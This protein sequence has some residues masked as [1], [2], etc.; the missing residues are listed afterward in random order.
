MDSTCVLCRPCFFN[1]IHVKHNYKMH[2]SSGG[3]YCDCGD[4]E[5]WRSGAACSDHQPAKSGDDVGSTTGPEDATSSVEEELQSELNKL[6]DHI[7][8]LPSSLVLRTV[9]LL[10]PLVSSAVVCLNDLLQGSRPIT[11]LPLSHRPGSSDLR[12]TLVSLLDVLEDWRLSFDDSEKK[13]TVQS[14]VDLW[15]SDDC[16]V[17]EVADSPDVWDEWPPPITHVPLVL[18]SMD[19]SEL[20][21]D[22][23]PRTAPKRRT[24]VDVEAR[25]LAQLARARRLH[26]QLFPPRP[27][28]TASDRT[29]ASHAFVVI[30]HNNEFHNY[31]QV[32]KTLRRVMGCSTQQATYHA[33]VVNRDGRSVLQT[34]LSVSQA[35]KTAAALMR[36]SSSLSNRPLHCS[37]EHADVYNMGMFFTL[38]LRWLVHLS[39]QVPS[40][41]PVICHTL[42]GLFHSDNSDPLGPQPV[43]PIVPHGEMMQ[44]HS[45]LAA[46]L[47]RHCL[48]W[49]AVRSETLRVI[50][51]VLLREP[52]FRRVFAIQFTR[53]YAK[54]L[55]QYVYD[56]HTETDNLLALSCQVFTV[57]S[58]ARQL[59][60]HNSV[61]VRVI[62]RLEAAFDTNSDVL[63]DFYVQPSGQSAASDANGENPGTA[64]SNATSSDSSCFQFLIDTLRRANPFE[65]G[66]SQT[67]QSA[68]PSD[69]ASM[70]SDNYELGRVPPEPR[71]LVWHPGSTL[72]RS[73]FHP[74]E[75]LFEVLRCTSYVLGSLTN[76]RPLC[77]NPPQS[78][79]W[80][81][82]AGRGNFIEYIRSFL[83]L[84]G[85]VQ[86]MNGMQRE[87][88]GHVEEE[89]EWA[90]GFYII[91]ELISVLGL[92]AQVASSDYALFKSV[93]SEARQAFEYRIG[94]LD[95]RFRLEPLSSSNDDKAAVGSDRRPSND[96]AFRSLG[97]STEV[98]AYDVATYRFSFMQPLPRFLASL[99]GHGLE[100]G[101]SFED[102]GLGD[103]AFVNLLIE[104]PLQALAF[105]AQY[106]AKMWVRNGYAVPQSVNNMFTSN[107]RVELIDRDLQLLQIAAAILPPDEF[108][109]RFIH[110]M[111]L[112]GYLKSQAPGEPGPGRVQ[113]VEVMLRTLLTLVTERSRPSVGSFS[114]DYIEKAYGTSTSIKG[115]VVDTDLELHHAP[116]ID[117]VIHT[118]CLRPMICSELLSHLPYQPVGSLLR[119]PLGSVT[120]ATSSSH[121]A[122]NDNVR[123]A[124]MSRKANKQAVE[125]ILPQIL[126]QL[127][128]QSHV[129]GRVVFTIKPQVIA[130]RFNRFYSGYRHAEQTAA[131]TYVS[132]SLKI[133]LQSAS[134]PPNDPNFP[135]NLPIPPP[136]PRPLRTFL[137]HMT[138]GILGLVRCETFV[139]L[140]R[141]LLNITLAHGTSTVWWSDTL[142]DLILHL[143]SVALYEDEYEYSKT[144]CFPFLDAVARVPSHWESE[145]ELE[146]LARS[147]HWL[148]PPAPN[149]STD[150]PEQNCLTQCLMKLLQSGRHEEQVELI[151][152]TLN[153]WNKV[154]HLRRQSHTTSAQSTAPG[155]AS[156]TLPLTPA[157]S[158]V[159]AIRQTRAELAKARRARIMAHMS[160]MQQTFMSAYNKPTDENSQSEPMEVDA[161]TETLTADVESLIPTADSLEIQPA[162]GPK[163]LISSLTSV[164][165][166]GMTIT[167]NL[168]LEEVPANASSRMVIAAH[169][170]RTSILS[171]QNS[172]WLEGPGTSE[173]VK[174]LSNL[175]NE[176]FSKD[177]IQ[178]DPSL[179]ISAI[180]DYTGGKSSGALDAFLA[181]VS[182]TAAAARAGTP[183]GGLT[184]LSELSC[185]APPSETASNADQREGTSNAE[186]FPVDMCNLATLEQIVRGKFDSS[187][188]R[189]LDP[190]HPRPLVASRDPI[191]EEGSFISCC[192]HPMHAA[193]KSKYA[194]QLK[195]RVDHMN[196]HRSSTW[197]VFDFRCPLCKSIATL[198][199]P[200]LGPLQSL[201]PCTWLQSRLAVSTGELVSRPTVRF[202]PLVSWLCGLHRWL[203]LY[204][205]QTVSFPTEDTTEYNGRDRR[206]VPDV[207]KR[208][209]FNLFRSLLWDMS[210]EGQ[211]SSGT[212]FSELV[213]LLL[214]RLT[215]SLLIQQDEST[216]RQSLPSGGAS[217]LTGST[218]DAAAT[219][220][221]STRRYFWRARR[222]PRRSST[223]TAEQNAQSAE[224]VSAEST[225]T[226]FTALEHLLPHPPD[227]PVVSTS[228]LTMVQRLADLC[229]PKPTDAL[230]QRSARRTATDILLGTGPI[231]PPTPVDL[232]EDEEPFFT[233]G[234]G[235]DAEFQIGLHAT[236][237][238][239][240]SNTLSNASADST[241]RS[242]HPMRQRSRSGSNNCPPA[243]HEAIDR[244]YLVLKSF[245][246][247]LNA[248]D[249]HLRDADHTPSNSDAQSSIATTSSDAK[250]GNH[251][252]LLARAALD[253]VCTRARDT[254]L[255]AAYEWRALRHTMAYTL[256]SSERALRQNNPREHFFNGGLAERRLH[257]LGNVIQTSLA[258]HSRHALVSRG[259]YPTCQQGEEHQF[260]WP[261]LRDNPT[262]WW[263]W[264]YC[265]PVTVSS[266][267]ET[268]P[269]LGTPP[270]ILH[271]AELSL[272]VAATED[273]R[274]LWHLLVPQLTSNVF[275]PDPLDNV[276]NGEPLPT[277]TESV[278]SGRCISD[279]LVSPSFHNRPVSLLWEV[280]ITF[281][282]LSLL[283][284]RPGLEEDGVVSCQ[285]ERDAAELTAQMT[286][287][288]GPGALGPTLLACDQGRPRQPIG[289][290]H[291]AHL[292][293]LC[294]TAVLVQALLAWM[295]TGDDTSA[296]SELYPL[297]DD[298]QNPDSNLRHLGWY[299]P[300][301]LQ[302]WQRL[303]LLAG[304]PPV[305]GVSSDGTGNGLQSR[306]QSLSLYLRASCL[307]FLRIAAF[308]IYQITGVPVPTWLQQSGER[309]T[310]RPDEY[311]TLLTYLDLPLGPTDLMV[312][313]SS[314]PAESVDNS[315]STES[316]RSMLD[317]QNVSTLSE[318]LWLARLITSWCLAGRAALSRRLYRRLRSHFVS[319]INDGEP[320]LSS[321]NVQPSLDFPLLPNPNLRIPRLIHL[322]REYTS[323]LSLTTDFHCH[324]GG[325]VH[326]D[327][328]VCLVCGHMACLVCYG[329]RLIEPQSEASIST[330][331]A[332]RELVVYDMQ[333][334]SRRCHS[335]YSLTL[336]LH[337]CRV[338]LLSDQAR[339]L[340][341][342]TSPYRDS[343][344]ETDPGLRRG[345]P[346][347]LVDTEYERL[348][349]LWLSHQ[350]ASST[351][352]ELLTPPSLEMGMI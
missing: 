235:E 57:I 60:E 236:T 89:L 190:W 68:S 292:L 129:N 146:Q 298:V 13:S 196:R 48:T 70:D 108:L 23:W 233:I 170:C 58:L 326:S 136:S 323:L 284:L 150:Y 160:N 38:F 36:T 83:R 50:M 271:V 145:E 10:K 12:E 15:S 286:S 93:L 291:D 213:S 332:R 135:E 227:P 128:T 173:I 250:S 263:W 139:R 206:S 178:L 200:V 159:A 343:F 264:A 352:S 16:V 177:N 64:Q 72:N 192:S 251:H 288:T 113:A 87:T 88:R 261:Q 47:E 46:T 120:C 321:I 293:R 104:R 155:E 35:A 336:R 199:L 152:W 197:F 228:L 126:R 21:E 147:R 118:L 351:S 198:D 254:I 278:E 142:L 7:A 282:F 300:Q 169:V 97:V 67:L 303:R 75:R 54:L 8:S 273:A 205:E 339:R 322:P 327:P 102:L 191:A 105:Y 95:R 333:A 311:L 279:R 188:K 195:A 53:S 246:E 193:C 76:V 153:H 243:L 240:A 248:L 335:G 114:L 91:A 347:F 224:S 96:L 2:T 239:A 281:L 99:Y 216:A 71:V 175:Q 62:S 130:S 30:L 33:I 302:V 269:R 19:A 287:E 305:N 4:L 350:L 27:T 316:L 174:R 31:E 141:T 49:R 317:E 133:W 208:F 111:Q 344:G 180:R 207:V 168:C 158:S 234:I 131:E 115:C 275:V 319:S 28:R 247:R 245:Y 258:A 211:K 151:Q 39:E 328:S 204:S 268:C 18:P 20:D 116:V 65:W 231:M 134:R 106:N 166:L 163:R 82:S 127:A 202:Q 289:D 255:S 79:G 26:P 81:N 164:E 222:F 331:G 176:S 6:R 283:H 230:V 218:A 5:A 215:N 267:D 249:S 140:L 237:F 51:S 138:A 346:L 238:I 22:S 101:F 59:L 312:I 32:I 148:N 45:W 194:R 55:Q 270:S 338:Y 103:K 290:A 313:L 259:C 210:L 295:P 297:F 256:V 37:C 285:C 1:S 308:V 241:D 11:T 252:H 223:T 40:L 182:T 63:P 272:R 226:A 260:C 318:S 14:V 201:V 73:R 330:G 340:T 276:P 277:G 324:V 219:A 320:V 122:T 61:L 162:L 165:G 172:G 41:R 266:S 56:D 17:N 90:S 229:Q 161:D 348:N 92:T 167:C 69:S 42:L 110:K 124:S 80:W 225:S 253:C 334:H 187:I 262:Q 24:A 304:L 242:N 29:A 185:G 3:G 345:N 149:P 307:P 77:G 9:R 301:L 203:E 137:P 189:P 154:V 257:S 296:V 123:P 220:T 183:Y 265:V 157:L 107:W 315:L 179:H 337:E 310:D 156:E 232:E 294:Y 34:G 78:P 214:N 85:F 212:E 98:Y 121:S 86:D 244:F 306:I 181:S 74:F 221:R 84:L 144:G 43:L 44:P 341:E 94:I 186:P 299:S 349:Q 25:G 184:L 280:D 52:F 209:D 117:S 109:A 342:M 314:P 171:S 100:M 274:Y 132:K 112:K 119:A 217:T 143:I 309:P 125:E 325:H 329:C 66:S